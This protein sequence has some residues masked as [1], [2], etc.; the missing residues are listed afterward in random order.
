MSGCSGTF[1]DS[2]G[3]STNYSNNENYVYT[4]CSD[5][6]GKCVQLSFQSF[7]IEKDFDFL[8]IYNGPSTS[9]P[10]LGTFTGTNSPGTITATSGCLTIR[11]SSDYTV[12]RG[13]WK[14]Y[15]NCINCPVNGCP[16]CNG[17]APPVNDACSGAQNL[18]LLPLPAACPNGIGA[19]SLTNTSNLCATAEIPYQSLQ[20]C[21]PIGSMSNPATDVWYKFS[22]TAPVL[23][24][25]INGLITPQVGLYSG[26]GCG[27]LVPRGCAIGGG[28]YLH[29]T[30]KPFSISINPALA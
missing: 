7:A 1:F 24:I 27:N 5:Q 30:A 16:T 4:I 6:P 18:G 14:A 25:T 17:G 23:D 11:F 19:V 12:N 13:G 8:F 10:L 15:I 3:D 29:T 9:S 2:G 22:L 20:G 21:K 26:T 28:G